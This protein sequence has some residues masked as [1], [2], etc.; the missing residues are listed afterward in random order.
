[1]SLNLHRAFPYLSRSALS[2]MLLDDW[3]IKFWKSEGI[4]HNFVNK[5]GT[6]QKRWSGFHCRFLYSIHNHKKNA[7][8]NLFYFRLLRPP[9]L[10]L[11]PPCLR[12][13]LIGRAPL[14]LLGPGLSVFFMLFFFAPLFF[15]PNPNFLSLA[16]RFTLPFPLPLLLRLKK[17]YQ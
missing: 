2:F 17:N 11:F 10:A 14:D 5:S 8:Q 9:P 13:F 12:P 4:C 15:P 16:A 7:K 1:M 6:I 3:C